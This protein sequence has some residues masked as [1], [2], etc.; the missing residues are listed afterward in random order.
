MK[1]SKVRTMGFER[2]NMFCFCL[3]NVS[4]TLKLFTIQKHYHIEWYFFIYIYVCIQC[5]IHN[6]LGVSVFNKHNKE[7]YHCAAEESGGIVSGVQV[8]SPRKFWLF[9]ILNSSKHCSRGSVMVIGL[10]LNELVF[11]LLRVL[12]LL[13]LDFC[14][15][16]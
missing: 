15:F 4:T 9:W 14:S 13:A 10:F 6:F 12:A 8:Q 1:L 11:T 16:G 5:F 2:K 3:K 7:K